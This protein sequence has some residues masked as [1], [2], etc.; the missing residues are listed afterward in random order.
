M[1][2][3]ERTATLLHERAETWSSRT[4]VAISVVLI[5]LAL[6]L[7]PVVYDG[8][9]AAVRLSQNDAEASGR[10]G[11]RSA[12]VSAKVSRSLSDQDVE[13]EGSKDV[14]SASVDFMRRAAPEMR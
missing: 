11:R 12:R 3:M 9:L 8:A 13:E 6:V 7:G 2:S 5:V 1:K 4:V 14:L 10:R